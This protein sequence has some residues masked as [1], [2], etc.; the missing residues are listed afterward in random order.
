[1]FFAV[2]TLLTALAMAGAAAWFAIAGIMAVFAGAPIPALVMGIVIET[3]KIV[4]VS[5]IYQHWKEKTLLKYFML[6]AVIVAML[7]TS[8][9]IFGFLSKAHL[10]QS[11]PVGN[12][13][14]QIERLDQRIAREQAKITDAETVVTQL[15]ETV[16]TLIGRE[17]IS[18]PD[19]ARAV[20]AGQQEQRDTLTASINEAE[21]A[22]ST[23][24]DE[25]YTLS[26]ELRELELE[27]GPVKYIAELIYSE[28]ENKLEDAVRVVIILFIFVF[29]PMAILLL[30][31]ANYSL[32]IRRKPAV[33]PPI[34]ESEVV[35]VPVEEDVIP[36]EELINL[37]DDVEQKP[38]PMEEPPKET[39]APPEKK[40]VYVD[41]IVDQ[42]LLHRLKTLANKRNITWDVAKRAKVT[43]IHKLLGEL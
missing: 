20:R 40:P 43:T 13:T 8:M 10:E 12:N 4:G 38:E 9:G 42:D 19:G 5:W 31:G 32:M 33:T 22:I 17:R 27:V 16:S 18:G 35:D 14:A 28:P 24:Q 15:D 2:I 29:D 41:Q 26:Q 30:M 6:P 21:V 1:M 25:K 37:I 34:V 11:A 36:G 3:G 7:L 23:L 39:S